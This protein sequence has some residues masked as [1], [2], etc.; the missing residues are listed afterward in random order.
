M[1]GVVKAALEKPPKA[2]EI[3]EHAAK[4]KTNVRFT[5]HLL[6]TRRE[7]T[8][9]LWGSLFFGNRRMDHHL[10]RQLFKFNI[11]ILLIISGLY[12]IPDN[13]RIVHY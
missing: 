11:T 13:I 12:E 2:A 4:R 6:R 5:A 1:S 8:A 7:K 10:M 9:V 3:Q